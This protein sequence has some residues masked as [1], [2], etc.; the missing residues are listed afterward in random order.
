VAK[1]LTVE[2]EAG[3][4]DLPLPGCLAEPTITLDQHG[5]E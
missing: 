1:S 5:W 4:G 2:P 3:L